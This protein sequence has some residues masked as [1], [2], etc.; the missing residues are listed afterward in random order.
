MQCHW[1]NLSHQDGSIG[2]DLVPN[3]ALPHI[4]QTLQAIDSLHGNFA[5]P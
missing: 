4:E 3:A 5:R 1:V 2:P